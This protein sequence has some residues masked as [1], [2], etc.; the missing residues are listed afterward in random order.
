MR[1]STLGLAGSVAVLIGVMA[2][3]TAAHAHGTVTSVT[4]TV[5]CAAGSSG[6][7]P[8]TPVDQNDFATGPTLSVG[9]GQFGPTTLSEAVTAGT[10][11]YNY[12]ASFYV[13]ANGTPTGACIGRVK[14]GKSVTC[15][16]ADHSTGITFS[17]GSS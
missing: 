9:C 5:T 3:A 12:N 11:A 15:K 13:I 14:L 16:Y 4:A 8:I 2:P 10:V 6:L 1:R 17:L 7:A